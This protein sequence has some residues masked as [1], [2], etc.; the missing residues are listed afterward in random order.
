VRQGIG[1]NLYQAIEAKSETWVFATNAGVKPTSFHTSFK[2]LLADAGMRVD[3][4]TG[5]NRSLYS[6]RHTYATMALMDGQMDMHTVAKQM[7]MSIGMLE[8][9]YSKL[10]ATMAAERLA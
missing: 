1:E 9:H 5:R 4:T 6:L 10:T 8:Q 2:L 3:P 7:G